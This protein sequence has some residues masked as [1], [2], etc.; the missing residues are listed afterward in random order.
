MAAARGALH[1]ALSLPGARERSGARGPRGETAGAAAAAAASGLCASSK[2]GPRGPR[3][4]VFAAVWLVLGCWEVMSGALSPKVRA[5][6][7]RGRVAIITG[8]TRG[9]GKA[10]AVALARQGCNI[11]VAAKTTTEQATLPG[12]RG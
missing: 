5:A 9:I 4:A 1:T 10:C 2:I 6:D 7:L 8:A 11:V 3:S 12:G